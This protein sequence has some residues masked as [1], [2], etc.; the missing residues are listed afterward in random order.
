VSPFSKGALDF[1]FKIW[2]TYI[3]RGSKN[4]EVG[5]IAQATRPITYK[6]TPEKIGAFLL[7]RA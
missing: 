1:F 2:H 5:Q 7:V 6:K 4:K 3:A